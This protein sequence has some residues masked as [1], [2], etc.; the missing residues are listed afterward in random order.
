MELSRGEGEIGVY[1]TDGSW[2][3][4]RFAAVDETL[5]F[6]SE[7]V[8]VAVVWVVVQRRHLSH[9]LKERSFTFLVVAEPGG[10]GV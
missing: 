8:C 7:P 2:I 9:Q 1:Q 4:L 10:G 5:F 3:I 6:S